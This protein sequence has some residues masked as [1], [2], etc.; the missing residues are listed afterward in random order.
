MRF[1]IHAD[2]R[3]YDTTFL[4]WIT[5]QGFYKD[6]FLFIPE[7]ESYAPASH[8]TYKLNDAEEFRL[9][10]GEVERYVRQ[11][12][13]RMEGYLE[14]EAIVSDLEIPE[15]PFNSGF[16]IP[17]LC[18]TTKAPL[19]LFRQS[20]IHVSLDR[21]RSDARL[22]RN[23]Q[24]MGFT[25]AYQQEE[26]GVKEI[27]TIQGSLFAI[28]SILQPITEYLQNAGGGAKCKVR[29]ERIARWYANPADFP[30]PPMIASVKKLSK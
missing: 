13:N 29:E 14:G 10:F 4:E 26:W 18:V 3:V 22:R 25:P 15:S 11:A 30:I 21:D 19:G 23:L 6:D 5:N 12:P 8:F 9:L 28:E 20:E 1:H 27:W 16:L 17:V 24:R 2:C 7:V